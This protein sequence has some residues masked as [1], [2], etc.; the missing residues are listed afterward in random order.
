MADRFWKQPTNNTN[1]NIND[2]ENEEKDIPDIVQELKEWWKERRKQHQEEQQKYL[3]ELQAVEAK[4]Q[5]ET[6]SPRKRIGIWWNR[7]RTQVQ[8]DW[9]ELRERVQI[10]DIQKALRKRL[11]ESKPRPPII[12]DN[13][14]LA[15]RDS[16]I[17]E[18]AA[19]FD[20]AVVVTGFND[21]KNILFPP[22]QSTTLDGATGINLNIGMSSSQNFETELLKLVNALRDK[23]KHGLPK[24][25][26]TTKDPPWSIDDNDQNDKE[27]KVNQLNVPDNSSDNTTQ[28]QQPTYPLS[29]SPPQSF[30]MVVFPALPW[31]GTVNAPLSLFVYP[32]MTRLEN[33]KRRLSETYPSP[34]L[35]LEGPSAQVVSDY[36]NQ[37]GHIWEARSKEEVLLKISSQAKHGRDKVERL[38]QDYAEKWTD[39][40]LEY[41]EPV[42]TYDEVFGPDEGRWNPFFTRMSK[43]PRSPLVSFDGVHPSDE[44]YELWGRHIAEA[45]IK[46]WKKHH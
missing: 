14:K 3:K 1:D 15:R 27:E 7:I 9:K 29:S 19:E 23:M 8:D 5:Q 40:T 39:E 46:E 34:V 41:D 4:D 10:Q 25:P 42:Y 13:P 31:L 36:E 20:V 33:K 45:I 38:M 6:S 11:S 17:P 12:L 30:P 35:F 26:T 16:T 37:R 32:I 18:L 2:N 44:G 28:N 24:R 21:L 22:K 43:K